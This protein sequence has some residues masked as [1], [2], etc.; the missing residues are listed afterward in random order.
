MSG[1]AFAPRRAV[2]VFVAV[3]KVDFGMFSVLTR[4]ANGLVST[5]VTR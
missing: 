3:N 4:G 2:G 1:L 5:L